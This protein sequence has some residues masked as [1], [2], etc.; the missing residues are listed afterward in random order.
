[1][2]KQGYIVFPEG[3]FD[4]KATI[5]DADSPEEAAQSCFDDG[6]N[7]PFAL[8]LDMNSRVCVVPFD[9]QVFCLKVVVDL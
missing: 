9:V 6:G 3:D 5:V 4:G 2:S 8:D 1:M 7:G